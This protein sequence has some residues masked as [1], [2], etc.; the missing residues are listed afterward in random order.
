MYILASERNGTLYVGMTSG[1]SRRGEQH[2]ISESNSFTK[3][4]NVHTLVYYEAY[5]SPEEAIRREK[6]IKAW[7]R[8]WKLRLI[9]SVN[10]QWSDLAESLIA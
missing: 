10:P 9:E 3:K 7:K 6:N 5:D 1:L 8:A 2:R 4:Y